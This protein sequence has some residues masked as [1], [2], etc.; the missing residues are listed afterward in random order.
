MGTFVSYYEKVSL[1]RHIND[2]RYSCHYWF[3]V[4][5]AWE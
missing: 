4:V 2:H 1:A 3:P 5:L